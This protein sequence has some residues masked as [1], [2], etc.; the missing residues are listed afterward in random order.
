MKTFFY[1]IVYALKRACYTDEIYFQK[2]NPISYSWNLLHYRI[3][4]KEEACQSAHLLSW[5]PFLPWKHN[6]HS[7]SRTGIE[8]V[9]NSHPLWKIIIIIINFF[10]YLCNP[11]ELTLLLPPTHYYYYYYYFVLWGVLGVGEV[12]LLNESQ[13]G[14]TT[15]IE[16]TRREKLLTSEN[17]QRYLLASPDIWPFCFTL[18]GYFLVR[19]WQHFKSTFIKSEYSR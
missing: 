10:A 17:S 18:G 6:S 5:L 15:T 3:Y 12:S 2:K 1:L 4:L 13:E 16:V 8:L 7:R 14:S 19:C 11:K 9:S